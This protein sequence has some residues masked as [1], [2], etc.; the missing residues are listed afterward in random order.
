MDSKKVDLIS[1]EVE[2]ALAKIA[3]KHNVEFKRGNIRYSDSHMKFTGL[4]FVE[5]TEGGLD[6]K[7]KRNF[8]FYAPME[9]IKETALNVWFKGDRGDMK[10]VGYNTRARK[11]PYML[12]DKSGAKYKAPLRFVKSLLPQDL[13]V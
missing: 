12:E 6:P 5:A 2:A 11:N 9:G 10:L 13:L 3:K 7:L 4:Q 8:E 1:A